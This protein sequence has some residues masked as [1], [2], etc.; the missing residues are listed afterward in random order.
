MLG[1][2]YCTGTSTSPMEY[3]S[4]ACATGMHRIFRSRRG[5]V[6]TTSYKYNSNIAGYTFVLVPVAGRIF[7]SRRGFMLFKDASK[8][9]AD[10]G[11]IFRSRKVCL[12]TMHTSTPVQATR[13]SCRSIVE[14]ILLY[15][16]D[17]F[18]LL[19]R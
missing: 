1:T 7:R 3:S 17:Y 4:T 2:S 9:V 6:L 18:V 16:L 15:R 5:D 8:C 12:L 14:Y 11:R 13:T 10:G 19:Y